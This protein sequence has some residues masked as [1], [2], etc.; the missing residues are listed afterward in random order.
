MTLAGLASLGLVLRALIPVAPADEPRGNHNGGSVYRVVVTIT[1][2]TKGQIFSPPVV[3]SHR[4]VFRLFE[5]R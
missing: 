5:G 1:N 4:P 2:L 3:V